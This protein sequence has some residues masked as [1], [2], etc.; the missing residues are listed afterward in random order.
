LAVTFSTS[1]G[2]GVKGASTDALTGTHTPYCG[3]TL[4]EERR[5][6]TVSAFCVAVEPAAWTA[7]ATAAFALLYGVGVRDVICSNT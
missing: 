2:S 3:F 7:S 6:T 5:S 4:T 1:V